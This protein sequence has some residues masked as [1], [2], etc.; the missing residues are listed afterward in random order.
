MTLF[1]RQGRN[2]LLTSEGKQLLTEATKILDQLDQTVQLFQHQQTLSNQNI[3]LS[4][5]DSEASHK[6]GRL[7]Q[8]FEEQSESQVVPNLSQDNEILDDVLKEK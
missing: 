5:S 2:I 8:I 7:I 3:F 4:Y 6:L 1:K